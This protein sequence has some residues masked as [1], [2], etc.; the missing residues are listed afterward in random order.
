MSHRA[1]RLKSICV[2]VLACVGA[3]SGLAVFAGPNDSAPQGLVGKE[4]ARRQKLVDEAKLNII[5]GDELALNGKMGEAIER[6]FAAYRSTDESALSKPVHTLARA[7]AASISVVHARELALGAR[8][9]EAN[10]VLDRILQP[11]V[12]PDHAPAKELKE[13]LADPER[14]NPALTPKHLQAVKKVNRHFE[15]ADGHMKLGSW[16]M[17]AL[18]YAKILREDP[19]NEAARRGMEAAR[20]QISNYHDTSRDHFRAKA[21]SAVDG[22]WEFEVPLHASIREANIDLSGLG[23][24][25]PI[26]Q[27][28]RTIIVPEVDFTD[29]SLEGVAE[30]LTRT[31]KELDPTGVGVN[32]VLQ[33][34]PEDAALRDRSVNL[35]LRSVPLGE[36][37]RFVTEV[38]GTKSYVDQF[39][40]VITSRNSASQALVT[41]TFVVPPD[42][43]N[44]PPEGEDE[45]G[46]FEDPFGGGD[47]N[48]SNLITVRLD[49]KTYLTRAGVTFPDGASA[50]HSPANGT[51]IVRNTQSNIDLVDA[52]VTNLRKGV[53]QMVRVAISQVEVSLD[54]TDE[55]TFDALLGQFNLPGSSGTFGGGGHEPSA[56]GTGL[57]GENRAN[58]TFVPP[59]S[60]TPVGRHSLTNGIRSGRDAISGNA[61]DAV[62]NG[63]RAGSA[64]ASTASNKAPSLFSIAGPF[65][66]PQFQLAIRAINQR[67][68]STVA[69]QP[70]TVTMPGQRSVIEV[71]RN[72]PYPTEYDPPEI[73]QTFNNNVGGGVV[74][75]D[76]INGV[77][78]PIAGFAQPPSSFPVTPAHPTA[79]DVRN[80]GTRFEVEPT[81]DPN[82]YVIT[83]NLSVEFSQF[84]GFIN[85]GTPIT[86][87][88]IELTD[89]RILQ[90]LFKVS[91]LAQPV[92][93]QDGS[94]FVI[95]GLMNDDVEFTNDKVPFL[96]DVPVVGRLFKGNVAER[97]RKAILF[98]VNARLIDPSG[99]PIN[100]ELGD[101]EDL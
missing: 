30:Y 101:G 50:V 48:K 6:Y 18:E 5:D 33:I 41:R 72:F 85:Y 37:V 28:L 19:T 11:D 65:T 89:N 73:P 63:E 55:L 49:A 88:E 26:A 43:L 100:R 25:D 77:F 14:Y 12:A 96:G 23:N 60:D 70:A 58:W 78:I 68:G 27:R 53:K 61:I 16:D 44:S 90:P 83:L 39:A 17:A 98:F 66:D 64:V 76:P 8:Y 3:I 7:R 99:F 34:G 45:A 51:L 20:L 32:F 36:I 42:F 47:A 92:H 74:V 59:G 22:A 69:N 46:G 54:S 31:S 97:R 94:N 91:R 67:K 93:V 75:F 95:G 35:I 82:G 52:L 2:V 15:I 4:I 29:E 79:F 40:V 9:E 10:K 81:I 87:G 84:E 57:E 71:F 80:I 56:F 62:A 24:S 21:L 86:D 1:Y 13:H 38:S